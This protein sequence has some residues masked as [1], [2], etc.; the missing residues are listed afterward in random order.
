MDMVKFYASISEFSNSI[1]TFLGIIIGTLGFIG[2]GCMVLITISLFMLFFLNQ[3]NSIYPKFNFY[4]VLGV[5][6]ILGISTGISWV[7]ILKYL[8]IMLIPAIFSFSIPFIINQ[9]GKL[10][11]ERR[12]GKKSEE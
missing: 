7:S 8:V 6:T 3:I 9:F 1:A 5:S 11:K 4:F 12:I 10:T 2:I